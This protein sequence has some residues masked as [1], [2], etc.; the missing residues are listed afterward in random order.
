MMYW[1]E[2]QKKINIRTVLGASKNNN[3]KKKRDSHF[4]L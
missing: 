4:K 1:L 2:S 3:N